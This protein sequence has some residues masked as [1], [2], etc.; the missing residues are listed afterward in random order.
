MIPNMIFQK[1]LML[2]ICHKKRLDC[3][4]S[5][6][7]VQI[8]GALSCKVTKIYVQAAKIITLFC[9]YNV[10]II[11]IINTRLLFDCLFVVF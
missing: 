3:V 2:L 7:L 8:N 1:S 10:D 11:Y 6:H 5:D 4:K 9:K